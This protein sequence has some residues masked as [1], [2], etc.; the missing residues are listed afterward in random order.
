MTGL[1]ADFRVVC[2]D[3]VGR[4]DS[5]GLVD[6]SGYAIAQYVSDMVTLLARL[7]VESLDWVGTSM[8][9]LIGM[10]LAAMSGTPLRRLLL[11][12][13]GPLITGVSLQRIGQY[14]GGAPVFP[15]LQMAEAYI[16][17]V[18]LPFGDLGDDNWRALTSCLTRP[19]DSGGFRM[20]YDPNLAAPFRALQTFEDVLL[21]PMYDA[22]R[23][24]TLVM[25]GA[26]SDLL[27]A[28]TLAQMRER[29]PRAKTIEIDGVGHAP[30][31]MNQAQIDLVRG[32]LVS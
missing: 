8:G 14:V 25:R 23:I 32:F 2:P 12:D 16:R 27:T 19:A 1:A 11:N 15:D 9:G 30:M 10:A 31:F 22:I 7:D 21:W 24:P 6:S 4:G 18:S 17:Q 29:G 5:D 26:H 3:A 20:H 28:Q 13:V